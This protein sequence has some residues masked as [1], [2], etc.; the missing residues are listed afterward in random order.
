MKEK[1]IALLGSGISNAVAASAVGCSESYVS[2][3][4]AIPEIS[5]R[6]AQ[7]RFDTLQANN[8]RDSKIDGIEDLLLAKLSASVN[9]IMRPME[10]VKASSMINAMKRRGSAAPEQ[11]T[12]LTQVINLT[13]P[14]KLTVAFQLNNQNE[15]IEVAGRP[16][17][18]M[19][20]ATLL[21]EAKQH[22]LANK[23]AQSNLAITDA[24][25]SAAIS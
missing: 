5:A 18:T 11:S 15:I 23:A 22:A 13:L 6:V 24:D 17:V 20:T 21:V 3:L 7:L 10:L 19:Q 8:L 16:L 4:L 12:Q 14:P 2:Q 25:I 9:L 1:L